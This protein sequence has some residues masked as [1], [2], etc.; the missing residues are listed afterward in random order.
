MD[1]ADLEDFRLSPLQT[2][3]AKVAIVTGALLV[4]VYFVSSLATSFVDTQVQQLRML[5][6]GPSLWGAVEQKLY[7]L[8]DAPDVAPEKK[9]KIIDA[10]HRVSSKYKPYFDA[11][12]GDGPATDQERKGL[13]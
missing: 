11:L 12:G 7:A 8:A 1:Q 10:L 5:S 9:K 2:F 4:F 3:F 6:G 13:Q